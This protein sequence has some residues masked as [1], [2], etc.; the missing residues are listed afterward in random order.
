MD[1][2]WETQEKGVLDAVCLSAGDWKASFAEAVGRQHHCLRHF[3]FLNTG[4]QVP[5]ASG[6]GGY[7]YYL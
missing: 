6:G 1:P 3:F 4:D 7:I 5:E 2:A